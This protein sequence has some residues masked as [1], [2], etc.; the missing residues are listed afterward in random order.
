MAKKKKNEE[1]NVRDSMIFE[2]SDRKKADEQGTPKKRGKVFLTVFIIIAILL[3]GI[4]WIIVTVIQNPVESLQNNHNPKH[5]FEQLLEA[6]TETELS[7]ELFNLKNPDVKDKAQVE[8]LLDRLQIKDE[9]G[10]FDVEIKSDAKP[11]EI[12]LKFKLSHDV[13]DDGYDLWEKEMIK[14]STAILS[15]VS[16]VAQV[17]W[18]YPAAEGE[19]NG[20]GFTRADAEKFYSLGVPATRFAQSPKSVQL[21]LNQLGIDLY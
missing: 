20:A 16:N 21:M 6:T 3:I 11:Y 8:A 13:P 19:K 9:L 1:F 4:P 15:L 2:K 5:T 12:T 10:G 14:Y 18:E 7:T 17:N